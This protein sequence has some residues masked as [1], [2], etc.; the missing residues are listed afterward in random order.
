MSAEHESP[1]WVERNDGFEH[2]DHMGRMI[3]VRFSRFH[4]AMVTTSATFLD[5]VRAE[6]TAYLGD[7]QPLIDYLAARR[8]RG[9]A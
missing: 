5:G 6:V 8:D 4:G 2:V 3:R 7:P 9:A 1:S